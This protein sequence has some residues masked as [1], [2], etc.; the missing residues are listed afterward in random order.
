MPEPEPAR[1]LELAGASVRIFTHAEHAAAAAAD[2]IAG[3]VRSAVALGGKAVLG[4]ATGATP[5]A[6]YARLVA[7]HRAGGLSFAGVT[8]YNLDEYHPISPFDRR[9]YRAY[10]HR[11]LFEHVDIAPDRAHVFDGTVPRAAA[12]EHAAQFGRWI[13]DDGGIDLQLLGIGRNA[14]IGFNEP[15]DLPLA[16]ALALPCRPITLRPETRALYAEEFGGEGL[17][18]RALTVGVAE[19][20]AAREILVLAFGAA[21]ADPVARSLLGP[22]TAGCPGSLLRAAPGR[23]TWMIDE[24]ACTSLVGGIDPAR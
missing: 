18:P 21:K 7:L 8:T 4:L 5:E 12:A 11:H 17:V 15:A 24:A 3:A 22:L 19:I 13:A 16:E 20:L 23:V 10:M 2:T 14:H 9:S 6:V 1:V